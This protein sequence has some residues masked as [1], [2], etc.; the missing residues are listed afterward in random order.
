VEDNAYGISVSPR[1]TIPPAVKI[2]D[3]SNWRQAEGHVVQQV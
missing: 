1:Q 2:F 3:Q